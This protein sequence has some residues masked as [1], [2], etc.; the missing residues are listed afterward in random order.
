LGSCS[1]RGGAGVVKEGFFRGWSLG[2]CLALRRREGGEGVSNSSTREESRQSCVTERGEE[3]RSSSLILFPR[4]KKGR[5][6][7]REDSTSIS[8][9][10]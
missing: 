5:R 1:E 3:D 7:K 2:G 6:T 4:G 8:E 9:E 10:D